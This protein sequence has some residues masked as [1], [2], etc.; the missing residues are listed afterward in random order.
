[1]NEGTTFLKSEKKMILTTDNF[2]F[3]K[4]KDFYAKDL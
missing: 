1:M 3:I 4:W 2:I